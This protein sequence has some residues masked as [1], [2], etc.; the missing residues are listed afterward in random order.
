LSNQHLIVSPPT[1]TVKHYAGA[2]IYHSDQF[3]EK[4]RDVL[5]VDLIEMMRSSTM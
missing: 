3:C 2:V 4:N 5:N 1:F